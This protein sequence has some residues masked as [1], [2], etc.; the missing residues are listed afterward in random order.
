MA[1]SQCRIGNV[2]MYNTI[3]NNVKEREEITY[4]WTYWDN[5][6]S[7]DELK[8][9]ADYCTLGGTEMGT[10]IGEDT[11]KEVIEKIRKSNVKFHD[12]NNENGWIFDKF[13]YAIKSL[14]DRFYGYNLNGYDSFQYTE[15]GVDGKYDWHQ[16][17]VHGQNKF[18]FTRKLSLSFNLTEPGVD[19]EGGDFQI[20]LGNQANDTETL[21]LTKGRLIAFPSYVIHRVTP[22]TKGVRKSIV[23][24]VVGPKFS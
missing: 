5:L 15:Y 12:R 17:M 23:I 14:N 4:P 13:N 19:Y 21:P 10:I 2:M 16:D 22:I 24:W 3:Y 1:F 8:R 7:P 20:N 6:F 9:L 18:N 11:N